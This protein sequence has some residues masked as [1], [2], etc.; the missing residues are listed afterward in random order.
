MT[1]TG[2]ERGSLKGD[3][4][5]NLFLQNAHPDCMRGYHGDLEV[6]RNQT[7]EVLRIEGLQQFD[8]MRETF[9]SSSLMNDDLPK[10]VFNLITSLSNSRHFERINLR[11]TNFV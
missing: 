5:G 3:R 9:V 10:I 2:F 11:E 1:S 7:R 8:K 6:V 4:S